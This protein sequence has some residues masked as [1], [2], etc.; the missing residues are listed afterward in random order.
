MIN[1]FT[2]HTSQSFL[3]NF[4]YFQQKYYYLTFIYFNCVV[5]QAERSYI[6]SHIPPRSPDQALPFPPILLMLQTPAFLALIAVHFGN[7]WGLYTLLTEIPTYLNNIQ[8]FSLTTVNKSELITFHF[9]ARIFYN[10][11]YLT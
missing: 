2:K 5:M 8:H 10:R 6:E 9:P 1:N 4:S 3:I 7:N 11:F